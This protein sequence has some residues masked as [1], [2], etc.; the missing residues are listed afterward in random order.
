MPTIPKA[1][2]DQ[3]VTD[4]LMPPTAVKAV[5]LAFKKALITYFTEGE[6]WFC[7]SVT[8]AVRLRSY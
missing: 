2:I 6:R 5:S 8:A 4:G 7:E 1:S 3:F